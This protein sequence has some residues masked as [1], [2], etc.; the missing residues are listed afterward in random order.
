MSEKHRVSIELTD[1]DLIMKVL[2]NPNDYALIINRYEQKLLRYILRLTNVDIEGAQDI[3]QEVFL[4]VYVNL[5]D[6]DSSLKF[7]SWIYRVAH[8]QVISE[9]RKLKSRAH[10]NQAIVEDSVLNNIREEFDIQDSC[11]IDLL[12]ESINT[13][14]VDMKPIY[15]D[16]LVLKYFEQKSY[17]EISDI[18]QKP[19]GTVATILNRA[20][21]QF[22]KVGTKKNIQF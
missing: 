10:G 8:N 19:M 15:K 2:E 14:L 13:I 20:K 18:L 17:E 3:L 11:D 12:R 6:F 5:N 4:K 21:K 16:V 7:S 22:L 1:E 9:F